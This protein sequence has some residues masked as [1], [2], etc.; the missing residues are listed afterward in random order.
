MEDGESKLL[1]QVDCDI[2]FS[3]GQPT[4]TSREAREGKHKGGQNE[5]QGSN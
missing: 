5:L 3:F 2:E 4:V 1:T